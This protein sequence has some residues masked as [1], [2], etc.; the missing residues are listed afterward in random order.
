[1]N[2]VYKGERLQEIERFSKLLVN[3]DRTFFLFKKQLIL[4]C[5]FENRFC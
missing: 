1:M 3:V 5:T 2:F 4:H